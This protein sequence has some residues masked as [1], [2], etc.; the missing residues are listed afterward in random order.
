MA[1]IAAS[2]SNI[3]IKKIL[4]IISQ[5][6]TVE[7]RFQNIGKLKN[8]SKV[9]LDYA[10]TPDALKT[11]LINLK[12][13]FPNKKISLLFGCGGNRDQIKRKKMGNIASFY[14]DKIYLTDDNPRFENPHRIRNDIK[15]GIKNQKIIEIPNREKAITSAINDIKTGEIL[16][17]A[18][19]GHEKT[20]DI[21][22]KKIYFSDKKIILNAIKI[23]N[24]NLL[25]HLKINIIKEISEQ[26]KFHRN[27]IIKKARID[28]KKVKKN[29]IFCNKR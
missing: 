14:S 1:I 20:Q 26:K 16:L 28:S 25:H 10:H 23:K 21:G 27:L 4:N 9:I 5:I 2:L 29:D 17:V 12:E 11:C 19:K 15:K 18:G 24:L 6:K 7:G 13:Q 22:T 3:D 8:K